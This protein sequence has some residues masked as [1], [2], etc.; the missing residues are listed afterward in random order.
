[1]VNVG[2]NYAF[3]AEELLSYGI[4]VWN[5]GLVSEMSRN[6]A[7][8]KLLERPGIILAPGVTDAFVA[9]IIERTEFPVVYVTGAGV[10]NTLGLPDLGLTNMNEMV[11]RAKCIAD[12]VNIPVI[13]D[14][15]TGYGNA[16]NVMRTVREFESAGVSGIH[17]EDQVTPKRCGHFEGKQLISKTEMVKK[18][19]AAVEARRDKDFVIIARTDARA[20]HGLKEA[21]SRMN[22]YL[23]AGADVAFVEAPTS[24]DE[25]KTIAQS[26]D[27]PLVANMVEGGKTPLLKTSELQKMGYKV[28]IYANTA[29]RIAGYAIKEA[30]TIL[31]KTGT[32]EQLMGRMLAWQERQELVNLP[33]YQKLE[34]RFLSLAPADR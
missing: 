12:A 14:A 26:I 20:Q 4:R 23:K 33:F 7:L 21:I 3:D 19:E 1:M 11:T 17:V 29:L 15:D 22:A 27:A 31:Q 32:T 30:M 18:I 5:A 9:K 34:K 2:L 24:I 28:V 25:L 13:S 10:S 8:R 16:L 6:S